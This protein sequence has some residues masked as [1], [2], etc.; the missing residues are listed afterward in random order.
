MV[1]ERLTRQPPTDPAWLADATELLGRLDARARTILV[2]RVLRLSGA[3]P[4]LQEL[5]DR[6]YLTRER[7]RQIESAAKKHIVNASTSSTAISDIVV[8]IRDELGSVFAPADLC[9]IAGVSVDTT[10]IA[11]EMQLALYLAGPYRLDEDTFVR[12]GFD[13]DLRALTRSVDST[14]VPLADVRSWMTHHGIRQEQHGR[15]LAGLRGIRVIGDQVVP[16]SGSI[17]DKAAAVLAINE[18]LMTAEEIHE[19]LGEGALTTLKN[20]LGS[21]SRFIRRGPHTWGL[22][23]WGGEKYEGIAIEMHDELDGLPHGMPV[24]RLKRTLARKFGIGASSIEIMTATHPMFVREGAW[25]RLRRSDE[26]YIPDTALEETRDCVVIDGA[27]S[28]RHVVTHDTLRGSGFAIPEPFA[29]HLKVVP[30][31]RRDFSS[32]AGTVSVTWPSQNPGIGSL[33][34]AAERLSAEKG[35]YL[36]VIPVGDRMSFKVAHQRHLA[37]ADSPAALLARLGQEAG[38]GPWLR[39]VARAIGLAPHANPGEIDELLD[40]RGDRGVLR[41]FRSALRT[42]GSA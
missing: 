28:W 10:D 24:D 4:T 40:V 9:T 29:A 32:D 26:P 31:S 35:D 12:V 8:R 25:V 33:R 13:E 17:G 38:D 16:W 23:E 20:Y 42:L 41:L 1:E 22:S 30:A 21:E 6:F 2:E 11:I 19:A 3:P 34:R 27:W 14:P 39:T 15:V 7:V 37:Q 5:G 18:R 36:F